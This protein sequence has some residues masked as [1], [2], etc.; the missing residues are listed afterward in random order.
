MTPR[1]FYQQPYMIPLATA[2]AVIGAALTVGVSWGQVTDDS[3]D[4]TARIERVEQRGVAELKA[5]NRKLDTLFAPRG[6]Q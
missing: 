2:L 6:R 1:R 5:I 3:G 4:N